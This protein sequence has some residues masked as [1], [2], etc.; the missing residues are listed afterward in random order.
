M[1]KN[2]GKQKYNKNQDD[3]SRNIVQANNAVQ[4]VSQKTDYTQQSDISGMKV[5]LFWSIILVIIFLAWLLPKLFN[6][7]EYTI[8]RWLMVVFAIVLGFF[9]YTLKDEPKI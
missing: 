5:A 7:H 1:K 3:N 2:R 4:E 6:T 8:E 9:L